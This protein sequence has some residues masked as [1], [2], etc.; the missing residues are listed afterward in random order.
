MYVTIQH[1]GKLTTMQVHDGVPSLKTMQ[2]AVGGFIGTAARAQ[3]STLDRSIDVWCADDFRDVVDIGPSVFIGKTLRRD[4][5]YLMIGNLVI[6]GG[7]MRDGK[8]VALNA[9]EVARIRLGKT[10]VRFVFNENESTRPD[11]VPDIRVLPV[12]DIVP[13]SA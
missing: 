13:F 7:D 2:Q 3:G 9:A 5:P 12:L 8:T 1:D 10:A 6:T 11:Y 4:A